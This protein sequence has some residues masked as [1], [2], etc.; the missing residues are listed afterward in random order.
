[1]FSLA[2]AGLLLP[3]LRRMQLAQHAYEDAPASHQIKTGTPTM[4]GIV[5][6][7]PHA[8]ARS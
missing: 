2:V 1:M 5:F 3:L 7:V 4:G 6:L 8:V